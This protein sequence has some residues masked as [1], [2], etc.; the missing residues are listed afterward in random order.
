MAKIR[1]LRNLGVIDKGREFD[2]IVVASVVGDDA[3]KLIG[4]LVD[5]KGAT[6]FSD[7]LEELKGHSALLRG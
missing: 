5:R 6:G 2:W 1:N 3:P 4:N 7:V